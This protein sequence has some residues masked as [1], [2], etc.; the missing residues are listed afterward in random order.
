MTITPLQEHF[1]KWLYD[2]LEKLKAET[3]GIKDTCKQVSTWFF[4]SRWQR[5]N[6]LKLQII[7][8]I[9]EIQSKQ[10]NR[11]DFFAQIINKYI[12]QLDDLIVKFGEHRTIAS[13]FRT[14]FTQFHLRLSDCQ[15]SQPCTEI[16]LFKPSP[17]YAVFID[18]LTNKVDITIPSQAFS[19]R[20]SNENFKICLTQ[21]LLQNE[22]VFHLDEEQIQRVQ[23]FCEKHALYQLTLLPFDGGS[24]S[25]LRLKY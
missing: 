5:D 15:P 3:W 13:S 20:L 10:C 7:A 12:M 19:S 1:V 17:K 24:D 6:E 11:F 16:V 14:F 21:G 18:F 2:S 8:K 9:E 4:P 23:A 25:C 22:H